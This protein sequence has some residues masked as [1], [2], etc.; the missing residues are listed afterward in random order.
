[1][2]AVRAR[3][4]RERD[5]S[6]RVST[7]PGRNGERPACGSADLAA[8]SSETHDDGGCMRGLLRDYGLSIVLAVMFLVSWL[9][10]SLAGWAEFAAD[11]TNQGFAPQ[12]FGSSGYVYTWLEATF[13]NWQSEFLQLFTFVVLT[14]FLIHRHSHES[15]DEQDQQARALEQIL[16]RLSALEPAER[17]D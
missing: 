5:E 15:R 10:Q 12:L 16:T 8:A 1:M 17:K 7:V 3:S 13:E 2:R 11:Q 9:I 4:I 6:H 14:T